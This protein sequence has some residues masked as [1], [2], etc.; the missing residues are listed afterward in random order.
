MP[1]TFLLRSVNDA[2][3]GFG[4]RTFDLE[5]D[6]DDAKTVTVIATTS[7]DCGK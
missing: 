5:G 1:G 6:V 3:D 4:T 7:I 2:L